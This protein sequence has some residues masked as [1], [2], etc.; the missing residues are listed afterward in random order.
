M[1]PT[2]SIQSG[3]LE[4]I[5]AKLAPN[6]SF[7]DELAELLSIS[8][9]SA[10]RRIRGETVLSLDEIR[11]LTHRYAISIDDFLSPA[12]DR[13][14]FQLKALDVADFSFEK[15]FKSILDNL[16]LFLASP[17]KDKR[18]TYDAK[19]LP[20]F[21]YFQ[22][23]RLSAFKL[24]FWMKTFAQDAKL[25][26]GKYDAKMV[27]NKLIAMGEKIWERYSRIPCTEIITYELL[28]VT[29]RQVEYAYECGMFN[30][31]EEALALCDDCSTL[32]SHL[33]HQAETGTKLTYGQNEAG[34][35][36]KI[37][38]NEVLIGSNSIL[39]EM[40]TKRIAFITPNNFNLLMTTHE[41]FCQITLN[42]INN[43]IEQSVLITASAKKQR[44][45]FFNR[46]EET[47]QS[48]K[49]RLK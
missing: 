13:V 46:V 40:G 28:N 47:I 43:L 16:E 27:D 34:A 32:A 20:I 24:Y 25:N 18:I 26:T 17:E 31:K 8:R 1:I 19:D 4:Q 33:Q 48:V 10:Y 14:S 21:Y 37:Y 5:K 42:H 6:L 30:H 29:L 41:A 35:N 12:R 9:D 39:F 36:F 3:F 22:F 2:D 45:K 49:S 23:P 15:W 44:S 38:V 7:V 11:L